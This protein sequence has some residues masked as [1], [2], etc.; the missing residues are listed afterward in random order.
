MFRPYTL[1]LVL[2]VSLVSS[3]CVYRLD[4]N[5]GNVIDAETVAQLELGMSK[6]QV[7]FLMGSPALVDRFNP[8]QWYYVSYLK[9][10]EDGSVKKSTLTL[11]FDGDILAGIEGSLNPPQ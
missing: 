8:D 2:F 10:G 9:S 6:S 11:R 4:V 1:V 5:Q 7:Q 3:A